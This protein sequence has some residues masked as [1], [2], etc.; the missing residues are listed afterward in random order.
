LK[1]PCGN[2]NGEWLI[3]EWRPLPCG[4]RDG[5]RGCERL[6]TSNQQR[7]TATEEIVL[8]YFLT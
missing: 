4:E 3:G 6:A 8:R 7:K 2:V 1:K 5:V